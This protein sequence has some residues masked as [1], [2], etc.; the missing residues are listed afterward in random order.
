MA[1]VLV[2]ENDPVSAALIEDRLHVTGHRTS[3]VED[4]AQA[5]TAAADGQ[6]DLVVLA[7]ELESFSG[8]G[9]IRQL[10]ERRETQSLPV[11]ALSESGRSE[12]RIAALRA[13]AD[14]YLTK[15]FDAEELLLR[16]D[17]LLGRRGEAPPVMQGDLASHPVWE[18]IQ[19]IQQSR[20]SGELAIHGTGGSG[21]LEIRDGR[22][23]N[24][25]WQRLRGREALLA[26]LDLKDG[27]FRLT[28]E[29]AP[30]G[31]LQSFTIQEVLMESAWIQDELAKRAGHLPATGATLR[32]VADRLP[33]LD[34]ELAELPIATIF[35]QLGRRPGLRLYDLVEHS[36]EAPA[37]V[38]LAVAW[39][40][41][42]GVVAP[43]GAA[44]ESG[45]M[46]TVEISSSVVLDLSIRNLVAAARDVGL[47]TSSALSYLLLAEAGVKP[48]LAEILGKEPG[49]RN[50]PALGGLAEQFASGDSADAEITT[51]AGAM[52]FN[53]RM[54]SPAIRGQVDELV[55]GCGG[56]FVWLDQ[57]KDPELVRAV[58]ERL[59]ATAGA[60]GV[61]VSSA[62]GAELTA[63]TRNWRFVPD[64]PR[65][66]IGILRLLHPKSG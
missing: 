59:E 66:L 39:L 57:G 9:V 31:D 8:L 17:R 51:E 48:R 38:R 46:T 34:E 23:G 60:V 20:K 7:L 40:V 16:V 63:G 52:A 41:E 2:L 42:Q 3:L 14:D 64:P 58:V 33:E 5:L 10:R 25:R 62:A 13:G 6:A 24:V 22:V 53:L 50:H 61:L 11:V 19:Y 55:P 36:K 21:Q 56:V 54:L 29:S 49:L 15:P 32:R 43:E 44:G 35:D 27:Q 12:D 28:S 47:D 45:V 26:L 37:K 1:K 4:P 30:G 18:L 65:S